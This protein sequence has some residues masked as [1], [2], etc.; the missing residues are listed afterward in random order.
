M[1]NN[2]SWP[3][4]QRGAH[5]LPIRHASSEGEIFKRPKARSLAPVH[6]ITES[7]NLMLS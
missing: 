4:R 7:G 5:A 1:L 2:V 3:L 6:R